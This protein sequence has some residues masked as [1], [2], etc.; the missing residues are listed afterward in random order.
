MCAPGTALPEVLL[1][2]SMEW[3]GEGENN[4]EELNSYW[5]DDVDAVRDR[6]GTGRRL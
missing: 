6:L 2:K 3:G 1:I 5:G 4:D